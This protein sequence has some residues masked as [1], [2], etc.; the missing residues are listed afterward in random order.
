MLDDAAID[1]LARHIA[2]TQVER[3]ARALARVRAR[4]PATRTVVAAGIGSFLATRAANR[5]GIAAMHL[6]DGLGPDGARS[7]PA[8]AVALL[9]EAARA[10]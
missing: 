3:I 7:A 9:L 10:S 5:L 2:S 8:V 4:H 6:A 1:A